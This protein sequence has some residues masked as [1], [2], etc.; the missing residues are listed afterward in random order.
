MPRIYV[1]EPRH[2]YTYELPV[3]PGAEV[4]VG[5]APHCHLSLPGVEGLADVHA[6]ITCQGQ[7]YMISDLGSPGGT[8][9]NGTPVHSVF[10]MP[11]VEYRMGAV[12]I[13]LAVEGAPPQPQYM[14]PP[15]FSPQP[16][17]QL[18]PQPWPVAP[19]PM[20]Q[21]YGAPYM[22]QPVYAQPAP[23][24]AEAPPAPQA[25]SRGPR[26]RHLNRDELDELKSRFYN[27]RS[28]GFPYGKI[29]IFILVL[30]T[31][32]FFANMLPVHREDARNFLNDLFRDLETPASAVHK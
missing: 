31:I 28:E 21:A 11:G 26:V 24:A 15:A 13:T 25:V 14:A 4:L 9:A 5:A 30:L 18:P 12:V 10:L 27:P 32:A 16:A 19:Q 17:P 29:I 23:A 8:F 20:Q 6:C 3:V 2:F 7:E 22:Q 1:T